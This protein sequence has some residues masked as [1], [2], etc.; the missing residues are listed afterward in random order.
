MRCNTLLVALFCASFAA[1]PLFA[2]EPASAAPTLIYRCSHQCRGLWWD[3]YRH[4]TLRLQEY[5]HF[6]PIGGGTRIGSSIIGPFIEALD[7]SGQPVERLLEWASVTNVSLDLFFVDEGRKLVIVSTDG[8][9]DCATTT[10]YIHDLQWPPTRSEAI[11]EPSEVHCLGEKRGPEFP[12]A[13]HLPTVGTVVPS[14]DGRLLANSFLTGNSLTA[15]TQLVDL[16]TRKVVGDTDGALLGRV[17]ARS[18]YV[19]EPVYTE[20]RHLVRDYLLKEFSL[21]GVKNVGR[22]DGI[23]RVVRGS[24]GRLLVSGTLQKVDTG[25]PHYDKSE[26]Q[27]IEDQFGSSLN[28]SAQGTRSSAFPCKVLEMRNAWQEPSGDVVVSVEE[29]CDG[30]HGYAL[31][32]L[33]KP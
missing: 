11:L 18:F 4:R 33:P 1:M 14:E 3:Q 2:L 23:E 20:Q 19:A 29:Q 32:R 31:Y 5:T 25:A 21:E 13:V 24:G 17:G 28:A 26:K 22:A 8:G 6:G 30:K 16:D 10:V 27:V 12:K 15:K 7:E 9:Y